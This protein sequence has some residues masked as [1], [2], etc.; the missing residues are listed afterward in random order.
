MQKYWG[1]LLA[2]IVIASCKDADNE[3][4]DV[5]QNV[6]VAE[7]PQVN[8]RFGFNLDEFNVKLDTIKYGDSFGELMQKNKVDYPKV[9]AI[10]ENFK[11]SFDVRKIRVGKPY[12][13]LQSKDTT[14]QAQV[15]IYE[16]DPINFTV[17]DLRDSVNVYKDKNKVK[18]VQRE[19]SG[20]IESSLSEAILEQGVD[21]NV[22]HNLAN[23]YAWTIDFSRLQKNDKFKIIYNEKFINDTVYAGA[24]PIEAAYFEH[25]G[26]PIYA[27]AYEN[28]SLRSLVDYFDENANNLRRTFLRMPVE[29]GRLSSRYN[30]K[31]RIKYYGYKLRPHKGTDY[32]APIGTPIMA[33]ADGT[34]VESTRRGGNGKYVKIRHNGTY[35]TQY[36]HMKAQKVKKGEFVRQGDVIGWIGM[37]GNTGGPHVCY[38]FWKNGKQVDPLQEELPQA[39]PLHDSLKEEYF[40]YIATY[41]EQLDCIIYPKVLIEEDEDLLTLNQENGTK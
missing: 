38:R 21:Y 19:V 10:S 24:E 7:V 11:D 12:T 30:L 35:S 28:D 14:A 22:T 39:E 31:R 27:F 2:L 16:N 32:A 37:T 41:K 4:K 33:T 17:V 15:F 13:I 18:F 6:K 26:K 3:K 8:E 29:Y 40:A 5:A 9:L 1:V 25:N 23:V 36:L 34:V 20:V